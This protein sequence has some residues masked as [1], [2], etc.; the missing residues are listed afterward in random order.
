MSWEV[1]GPN[2]VYIRRQ[3]VELMLDPLSTLFEDMYLKLFVK[4]RFVTLNGFAY[5]TMRWDYDGPQ[6][7]G[8]PRGNEGQ[9]D[10]RELEVRAHAEHDTALF[11]ESLDEEDLTALNAVAQQ[12]DADVWPQKLTYSEREQGVPWAYNLFPERRDK[13][14]RNLYE[15]A[16]PELRAKVEEWR[17]VD[18][19]SATDGQLL[20]G[21]REL[22][23]KET[24]YW[25]VP[26]YNAIR[27]HACARHA[28]Q[29]LQEFL[30][31][32]ASGFSSGQF[33]SGMK[34][35]TMQAARDLAGIA[36]MIRKN[37]PIYELVVTTPGARL[38][39][40]LVV[41]HP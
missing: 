19:A 30:A 41:E 7:R 6:D 10:E 28:D 23:E 36:G 18:P 40:A 15:N 27:A 11:A 38:M 12:Y 9:T 17:G 1:E 25:C 2:T 16:I 33:L 8:M 26:V 32:H 4:P 35:P 21:M 31:E 14:A 13:P 29:F 22:V 39:S 34:S 20:T 37:K 24:W 3:L 5:T